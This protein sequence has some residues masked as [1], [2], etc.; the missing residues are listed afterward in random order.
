MDDASEHE[1]IGL[2]ARI[3][4]PFNDRPPKEMREKLIEFMKHTGIEDIYRHHFERGMFIAQNP[5]ALDDPK[6]RTDGLTLTDEE[7]RC[8]K[9]D[10]I[11]TSDENESWRMDM[12][13]WKLP[14]P[15]WRLVMLC[16]LGAVVQ[17]WD[18]SAINSAQAYYQDAY[19]IWIDPQPGS[20]E[21]PAPWKVGLVNSAP[22][23]CCVLSCWFTYPLNKTFGRR[24]TIVS[25]SGP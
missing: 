16:A 7:A 2:D 4:N 19:G 17:G 24:W 1:L 15:L 23:L 13:K 8:L 6:Y 12:K 11:A 10:R 14:A 18:E 21:R 5:K 3:C 25:I 20:G 22:Y 9:L